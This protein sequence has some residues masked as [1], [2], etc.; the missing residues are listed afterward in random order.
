MWRAHGGFDLVVAPVMLAVVGLW[1]DRRVGTG[2][3][4][5]LGLLAF[6]AVGAA[7]KVYYDFRR[8]M[9]R[10]T[11]DRAAAAELRR[12]ARDLAAGLDPAVPGPGSPRAGLGEV[13]R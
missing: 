3:W 1:L 7:L 8:A 4:L 12:Q 10:A 9:Q 2:P 5:M 6:G 13:G 11:A